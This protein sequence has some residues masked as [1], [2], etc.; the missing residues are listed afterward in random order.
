MEPVWEKVYVVPVWDCL[1][2]IEDV[3]NCAVKGL[4][5]VVELVDIEA[6][7]VVISVP[8]GLYSSSSSSRSFIT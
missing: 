3:D 6:G 1:P 4:G 8:W 2:F 5:D 7:V